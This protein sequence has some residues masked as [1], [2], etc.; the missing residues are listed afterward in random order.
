MSLHE[1]LVFATILTLFAFAILVILTSFYFFRLWRLFREEALFHLGILCIG[2]LAYLT[3]VG[4]LVLTE[5]LQVVDFVLKKVFPI[6]FSILCLELSLFYLTL[7]SNRKSL[8]EKYIPFV[9]GVGFGTSLALLGLTPDTDPLYWGLFLVTYSISFIL[10]TI[11]TV[12]IALRVFPLIKEQN[13]L[14]KGDR[15][16]LTTIVYTSVFLFFGAIGD[17]LIFALMIYSPDYQ[18]RE[19]IQISGIVVFPFLLLSI[20]LIRKIIRTFEDADVIHVMNLLS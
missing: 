11:L 13:Q 20:W 1:L 15:K 17:M 18:W 3:V 7:F 12:K 16:F 4:I 8:W 10:I 5:D 6:V 19:L 2:M 9:F 14:R